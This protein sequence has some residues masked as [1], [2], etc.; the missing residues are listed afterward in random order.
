MKAQIKE[1][2]KKILRSSSLIGNVDQI[3]GG[4]VYG[5][6]YD[7]NQ[8]E[9]SLNI[10]IE[11]GDVILAEG[12]SNIFREDLKDSNIGNG[13]HGFQLSITNYPVHFNSKIKITELEK[14]DEVYIPRDA[15]AFLQFNESR[16][17]AS[18]KS[19]NNQLE[20]EVVKKSNERLSSNS[21]VVYCD[22]TLIETLTL[23]ANLDRQK[24]I[25]PI[26][27]A[28]NNGEFH[29]VTLG[30]DNHIQTI[31][32]EVIFMPSQMTPW[33]YLKT[34]FV[35]SNYPSLSPFSA[36]KYNSM[37]A[38]LNNLLKTDNLKGLQNIQQAHEVLV[39]GYENRNKFPILNL[40]KVNNPEISIIIPVHNKFELTYHAIA[41]IILAPTNYSYEVVVVDD[42]STDQTIEIESIIKNVRVIKNEENLLF[43]RNCNKAAELVDG[44]YLIF[45]NNDVEVTAYWSD[46]LINGLKTMPNAGLTGSKLLNLDGTLQE[47]GGIVWGSGTPWNVGY[48][49]NAQAPEFNYVRQVDYLSGAALA[50]SRKVWNKVGGFS[51]EFIPAYYEDT[52]LAFKIRE[53]GLKVYYQPFSQ[54]IHFEGMSH[55]RDVSEGIKQYQEVNSK[56]F[57]KKWSEQYKNNGVEGV[58][59]QI[60]KDRNISKRV[61]AIDYATPRPDIDA[62]SY[63]AIQ[64]IKLLQSFGMKVSFVPEN[65][66]YFGNYSQDLQRMGV[67]VLF[68]PFYASIN[69]IIETR[70]KEFDIFYI[71]RYN[72]A[73]ICID[74]IKEVNPSAKIIFNNADLHFLRELRFSLQQKDTNLKSVNETKNRE[75]KVMEKVDA[76]LSYNES[77]HAI[78]LSH[79]FKDENIFLCPWVL[80]KKFTKNNFEERRDIVFLGNYNHHPNF[81]AVEFFVKEVMPGIRALNKGIKFRIY[82]SNMG[83]KLDEFVADDVILD[84]YIPNL[85]AMFSTARIF[86]AP[87]LS[88]AGIKGKVLESMAYGVPTILSPVAAE[89]TGL[90]HKISTFVARSPDEWV[91]YIE[92]LYNNKDEWNKISENSK[93]IVEEKYSFEKGVAAFKEMFEYLEIYV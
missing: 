54:V 78:I 83:N 37:Y 6:A 4:Y 11:F 41:S 19:V 63:A 84:G 68:Y 29:L 20:F 59:L 16:V 71:T 58:N 75:L 9:R 1:I 44:E 30:L 52:D 7:K 51:E 73:E 2:A 31:A 3:H 40:P 88:G 24:L 72:I 34:G 87:L 74:K 85:E 36:F 69:E 91:E 49:Q 5:W 13:N 27:K 53:A 93:I 8:P 33:E 77:E 56:T 18:I 35:K 64:E 32:K 45:L 38:Q 17:S 89:G 60:E 43:L 47:A 12:K 92:K 15:Q 57:R 66:A 67:E 26:P 80:E 39:E 25:V 50:I 65:M 14:G 76:I 86:L 46:E 79:L 23:D 42:V 10:K 48:G 28:F 61:L 90:N 55:G 81:Q 22:N 82:G 70:G 21:L 62:G